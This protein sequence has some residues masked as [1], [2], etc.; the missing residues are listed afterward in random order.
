MEVTL[1]HALPRRSA[2]ASRRS[3]VL[4]S[5]AVGLGVLH[6]TDHV[7][8]ADHSGWPFQPDVTPFSFSLLV[9]PVFLLALLVR[10][11][12]AISAALCALILAVTQF[13][14][15][16]FELPA[17]QYA[18]WATGVSHHA[19]SF[20][21]PNLL[22]IASPL[23]GVVAVVLSISLSVVLLATVISLISDARR[24]AP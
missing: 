2:P 14:H 18:T 8:R 15:I 7:L 10:A 9:Y 1:A 16:V 3:F 17:D 24:R 5:V 20:N 11:R 19:H 23:M 13:S 22:Q 6:H 12:P 21:Q 4:M